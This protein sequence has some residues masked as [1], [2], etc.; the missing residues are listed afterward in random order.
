MEIPVAGPTPSDLEQHV[1]LAAW[2][3]GNEAYGGS[4]RDELEA[5]TG[6]DLA[7]G[8]IYVTLI[9]LEK[10]GLLRSR[11]SDPTPV[12]GGKAKRIFEITATGVAG[13]Q[14]ARQA[15]DR[16]WDGLPQAVE[17]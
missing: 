12:R 10:K 5:K 7:Q 3:L 11:L 2:R 4:V 6:R 15:L 9:R 13:V 14:A 16:L 1:L 17:G 8:A